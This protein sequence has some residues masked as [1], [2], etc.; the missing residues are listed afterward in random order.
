VISGALLNTKII[1]KLGLLVIHCTATREGQEVSAADIHRWHTSPPPQGRGWS[2]VGYTDLIHLDGRVER[3]V[4]N[5]E[6]RNVDPF[7]V[8]NGA[9]GINSISRHI[10]YTG[11]LSIDG[12]TAKDT[13]TGAQRSVMA[14]YV[15]N[16]IKRF[17]DI[18]V[19]GHNQFATKACPS[20]NVPQFLRLIGVS[21]ENIYT[22]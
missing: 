3:L 14:N 9:V 20:F 7:E 13:R 19:A 6:D 17:P 18:R 16:F 22:K 2:Q 12:V 1:M 4:R 15:L 8:T 21:P 5:N 11:G 10:V